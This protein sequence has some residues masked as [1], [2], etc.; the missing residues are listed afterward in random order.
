MVGGR[1]RMSRSRRLLL[2][3]LTGAA[4]AAALLVVLPPFWSWLLVPHVVASE[5]APLI[6]LVVLVSLAIVWRTG[7]LAPSARLPLAV[8]HLALAALAARPLIA[9]PGVIA[10]ERRQL[11]A[12]PAAPPFLSAAALVRGLGGEEIAPRAVP[13]AAAD[14]TPLHMLLFRPAV[15]PLPRPA[16]VVVY[17]GAWRGGA[18]SQAANVSRALAARG[19]V[20]VAIDYR[21]APRHRFP[22]Q[23]DDVRRS[24]SLVVDS[25]RAWGIDTARIVLLG[26]SAGGHLAALAA[27]APG[28]PVAPRAVI[29]LYAPYDL[30]EGYRD[31]PVPDPIDVR[32]VLRAFLG[33]TPRSAPA[34]YAA[35]S[36]SS[37]VRPGLPPVL[38]LF[39]GGDHVVKPRFVRE[40]RRALAAQGN[41]VVALELP[42]AEHGFDLVPTGM[43][44]QLAFRTI[45]DFITGVAGAPGTE[46]A[47]QPPA[48]APTTRNGSTPDA[49]ASGSR[50]SRDSCDQSRSHT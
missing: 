9:L 17:G 4:A 34:R 10:E 32:G 14:G 46:R 23:L 29:A 19:M 3:T 44:A 25:A 24:L 41:R 49:T 43:G 28:A 13:Y 31:L 5:L 47:D 35:A 33:G 40:A 6:L 26:R 39:G 48:T 50:A 45:V 2:G 11:A 27:F 36:P 8:V 15:T 20:V 38:L 22:A 1:P 42:W 12:A 37:Y 18:P 21:H 16:V 30:A 7:A